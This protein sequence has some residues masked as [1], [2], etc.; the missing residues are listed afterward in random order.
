MGDAWKMLQARSAGFAHAASSL[1]VAQL[2]CLVAAR[3]GECSIVVP[4]FFDR[5]FH[6]KCAEGNPSGDAGGLTML[7]APSCHVLPYIRESSVRVPVVG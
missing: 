7:V 1:P 2:L 4:P 5:S 6:H 3:V